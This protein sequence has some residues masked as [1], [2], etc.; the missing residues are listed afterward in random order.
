[1]TDA[2]NAGTSIAHDLNPG[3]RS[4][5]STALTRLNGILKVAGNDGLHGI[6]HYA[7]G[8]PSALAPSTSASSSSRMG[9]A[10]RAS[11]VRPELTGVH[12]REFLGRGKNLW[13]RYDVVRVWLESPDR[14]LSAGLPILPLVPVSDLAIERLPEVLTAV[15]ERLRD[16]AA[17]E[18]RAT[19]WAA[20]AILMGLRYPREQVGELIK[21]VATMVLGIRGIEES[22]VY[23][24]ILAKG[25][26]EGGLE[27]DRR[28]LLDLGRDKLGPPDERVAAQLATITDQARLHRLLHGLLRVSTWDELLAAADPSE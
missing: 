1:M 27:E 17:P 8:K 16:E 22:W 21:G 14:L 20:T 25:R 3:T 12:E 23:Q 15:A 13:F 11:T 9:V 26:A 5:F 6:E 24:D 4:S 7:T 19:L 2:T 28:I 10:A 18:L